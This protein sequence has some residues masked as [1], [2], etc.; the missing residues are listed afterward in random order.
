[1]P[2]RTNPVGF[3]RSTLRGG[4]HGGCYSN[5]TGLKYPLRPPP[6][7]VRREKPAEQKYL[8]KKHIPRKAYNGS[9]YHHQE[10]YT[11]E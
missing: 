2:L 11:D 3:T 5:F 4:G 9:R 10:K 1:M 6:L 8:S 7:R